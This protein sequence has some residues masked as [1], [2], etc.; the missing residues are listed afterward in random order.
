MAVRL[1]CLVVCILAAGGSM[2]ETAA[3]APGPPSASCNGGGCGGWFRSNVTVSWSYDPTGVT[4]TTG[5]GS[6]VVTEDTGGATF[7]CTVNYGG[8]FYGNSVT[9]RKDSSPPGVTGSLARGPDGNGWYTQP[10][11]FSFSGD[12]GPSGIASC[13]SGTYG[14]PD[15]G[16]VSISGSC[17]DGAGNSGSSSLTIKYDATPPEVTA[18]P[19]RQPDAAGWYNHA[20]KVV[21]TGK[22]GGSGI[23]QCTDPVMYGGPDANPAKIVGQCRDVAGHLSAPTTFELRYDGTKPARPNVRSAHRGTAIA[24]SWTRPA[25][26]VRSV[27]IRV[28]GLKGK[29]PGVVY[30]GKANTFV[31]RKIT[32]GA[33]YRYE[34]RLY[35]QAGN[36]AAMTVG[37][38]PGAGIFSPV[39][40]EVVK[41]PPVVNW[42]KVP[43]ARFYNVQL[44]RGDVKLLTIVA[45]V[46]EAG[47]PLVLDVQREEAAVAPG[48]LPALRLA[49]V[50]DCQG[51][52]LR[53][54]RWPGHLR[55]Q[56]LRA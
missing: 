20:V 56:A 54:G 33:R 29:K 53:Q 49:R 15:G 11:A 24:L 37:L 17:T 6:A 3:A 43:K 27:V 38:K 51:A 45:A 30:D 4:G 22:D 42:A 12:G 48:A 44:W 34:V 46:T 26:V 7:V 16:A 31:D 41:R 40:G 55:R 2:P 25:D 19:E 47:A 52:P 39:E 8:P 13:S 35:D 36:L 5:C 32:P 10:V 14:G 9:V 21:F 50:R 1:L 28:P 23:A 18:A